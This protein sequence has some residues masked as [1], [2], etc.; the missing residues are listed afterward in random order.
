MDEQE[1]IERS[2]AGDMAALEQLLGLYEG[3]IYNLVRRYFGN[4]SEAADVGQEAMIRVFRKIKEFQG[5][6]SF[7]TWLYRVVTNVCLD[8]LRKRKN[9]PLSLDEQDEDGRPVVR[10][11]SAADDPQD[12]LEREELRGILVEMIDGMAKEQRMIIVLRDMEG[13]SYE[14][15]AAILGCSLG[16]VKSRLARAREA[17]RRKFLANPRTAGWAERRLRA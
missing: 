16:T 4:Q 2:Q 3:A 11:R 14:E 17:L 15:I 13:L 10:V 6:S 7:K 1:L 8:A 5:R 12:A 9:E